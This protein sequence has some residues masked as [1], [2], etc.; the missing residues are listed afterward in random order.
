MELTSYGAYYSVVG[1]SLLGS[2]LHPM[3]CSWGLSILH[4]IQVPLCSKIVSFSLLQ[5][6]FEGTRNT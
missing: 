5:Y 6:V 2:I 4:P 3:E 1:A